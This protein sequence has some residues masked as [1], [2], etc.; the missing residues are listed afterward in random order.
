MRIT[1]VET[2]VLKH[3]LPQ[4]FGF[5]QGWYS[6]RTAML[7]RVRTDDGL[8]GWGESW[9]PPDPVRATIDSILA[10]IILGQD[11]F[12]TECLWESMYSHTKDY[13]QKGVIIG[14]ISALDIAL[15]DIKGKAVGLPV[16]KLLGGSFRKTIA[17]Y[18]SG[19]YLRQPAQSEL[20]IADEAAEHVASGFSKIKMKIG[21][22]PDVDLKRIR[23]V[24][25]A[26][27]CDVGLMVDANH[28]Y[29]ART[30]INLGRRMEEYDIQWFEEPVSPEDIAG[31]ADV[32]DRLNIPIAGGEAEF[33]RFGFRELLS[34]RA[35][36]IIQ[37]DVSFAGGFTECKK[38]AAMAQSWYIACVPHVWGS[39][40]GLSAGLQ[41]L[42]SLPSFPGCEW[43]DKPIL[44]FDRSPNLFREE[45]A[46]ETVIVSSDGMVEIPDRPG[47]G[48][49]V[50]DEV[51]QKYRV[52]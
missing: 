30:A 28:A 1:S 49:T 48:V 6:T 46:E 39:A 31:Y 32:R 12:D 40:V 8:A 44:E 5:S 25:N 24:R 52:G 36:D 23:I 13:G 29:D 7:V 18:A 38:I 4:P 15:W 50:R 41:F 27:G 21:F 47:L 42:A 37:P 35:V 33:T 43:A 45:L 22:G 3:P 34:R 11:P 9:G 26:V 20:E 17:A 19:L 51:L 14:A 2:F 10:P 16:H